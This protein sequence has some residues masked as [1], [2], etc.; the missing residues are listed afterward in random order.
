MIRNFINGDIATS[1]EH[2]STGKEETRQACICR[3]RLFLGEYFLDATDGTPWFQEILG[4]AS[5]DIAD[6]NLKQRILSAR[7]V[8]AVNAFE[9]DSDR[10][11]RKLTI[12]AILTDI[13]NEQ[14]DFRFEKDL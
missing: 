7:G 11:N 5:R 1:G 8:M 10:R 4:K 9:L 6:A 13:N 3:L 14:F 12:K 2:F